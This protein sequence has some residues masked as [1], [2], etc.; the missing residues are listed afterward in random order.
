MKNRGT[1]FI[2]ADF[3][4]LRLDKLN[5]YL[6]NVKLWQQFKENKT[7]VKVPKDLL[8]QNLGLKS[9][10]MFCETRVKI[11]VVSNCLDRLLS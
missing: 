6:G 10:N 1:S 9:K 3:Y 2:K 8:D 4:K 11:K 7:V 5:R